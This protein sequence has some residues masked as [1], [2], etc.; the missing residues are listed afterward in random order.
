MP[1]SFKILKYRFPRSNSK[2][3]SLASWNR[4]INQNLSR[5]QGLKRLYFATKALYSC[6]LREVFMFNEDNT[7][8]KMPERWREDMTVALEMLQEAGVSIIYAQCS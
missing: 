1:K 4:P 8:E 6:P 5:Y 3:S 2:T 7:V